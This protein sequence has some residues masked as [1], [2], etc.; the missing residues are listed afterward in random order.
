LV[1]VIPVI[2]AI[3]TYNNKPPKNINNEA[4]YECPKCKKRYSLEVENCNTCYYTKGD[5]SGLQYKTKKRLNNNDTCQMYRGDF[6][7]GR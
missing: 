1:D 6:K 3:K 2:N 7:D 5:K 4:L